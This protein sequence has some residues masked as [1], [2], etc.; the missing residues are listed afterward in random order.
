MMRIETYWGQ[1]VTGAITATGRD[2]I[3]L[4]W[5]TVIYRED[6]THWAPLRTT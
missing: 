6:I 5:R 3:Q 2:W 1:V 4:N